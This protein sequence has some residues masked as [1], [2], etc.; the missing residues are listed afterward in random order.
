MKKDELNKLF[1]AYFKVMELSDE[2]RKKRI[3]CA[4][5]FYD[6]VWYVLTLIRLDKENDRLEDKDFYKRSLEYRLESM[7]VP[8][9]NYIKDSADEIIDST[10]RNMDEDYFLSEDRAILIAQNEA[11]TVMNGV[12]F[13]NAKKSGKR[14]KTWIAELD[15]RTRPDHAAVDFMKIPIDDMF[16]VGNDLMRFPHDYTA[17]AEN[18]VNCRCSCIYE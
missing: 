15:D 2:D 5:F 13:F 1:G 12:D 17:S 18:V 9:E 10:F 7:E 6:A 16:Q 4:F 8:Y 3:D 14:Y 11:N